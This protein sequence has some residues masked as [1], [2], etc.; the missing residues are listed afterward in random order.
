MNE[1]IH[2]D[3]D[4]WIVPGHI[5]Q[6]A[7]HTHGRYGLFHNKR[8]PPTVSG[9]DRPYLMIL[10]VSEVYFYLNPDSHCYV[11]Q[12]KFTYTDNS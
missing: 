6:K 4:T 7:G 8:Y 10:E 12:Q 2:L 5:Q 1:G 9:M 11:G 3:L